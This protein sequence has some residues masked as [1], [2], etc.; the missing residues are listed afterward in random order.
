MLERQKYELLRTELKNARIQAKLLQTD[1]AK[2]LSKPQ[3]Y[4]SKVE[5]GERNL[6]IIEFTSYCKALG[7]NPITQ[8]KKFLDKSE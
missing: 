4:V 6:D 3:S 2:Q 5:S 1:L 8:L 7:I